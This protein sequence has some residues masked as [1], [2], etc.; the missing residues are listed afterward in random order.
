MIDRLPFEFPK[1]GDC[2]ERD[3][4]LQ[5]LGVLISRDQVN[6]A[7]LKKC[8]TLDVPDVNLVIRNV[9]KALQ[10]YVG[11]SRMDSDYCDKIKDLMDK[12]QAWCLDIEE[13]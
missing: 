9:Q 3:K 5:L 12:A 6:I 10:K 4:I 13:I 1:E 2:E 11:F 8:Q 7:L